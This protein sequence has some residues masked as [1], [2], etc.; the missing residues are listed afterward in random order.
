MKLRLGSV[1]HNLYSVNVVAVESVVPSTRL[2]DSGSC[3]LS[4]GIQFGVEL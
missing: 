3:E 1:L 4:G 2:V